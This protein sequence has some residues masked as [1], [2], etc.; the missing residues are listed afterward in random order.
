MKTYTIEVCLYEVETETEDGDLL[1]D[2]QVLNAEGEAWPDE[3]EAMAA[4]QSVLEH[5]PSAYTV[6]LDSALGGMTL[7]RRGEMDE[8]AVEI[9]R[10]LDESQD[11]D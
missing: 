5:V 8:T 2:S 1:L 3:R 9:L 11:G 10:E 7:I 6:D 4:Y